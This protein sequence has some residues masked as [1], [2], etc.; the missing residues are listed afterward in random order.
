MTGPVRNLLLST[1]NEASKFGL[2]PVITK[3]R[4]HLLDLFSDSALV[5]L[6]E[7][8]PRDQLQAF[9]MGGDSENRHEWQPV[10]T[11]GASGS[12]LFRA[13]AGGRL[14]FNIFRV[15]LFHAG[16]RDLL[17]QLFGE[18]SGLCPRFRCFNETATLIIS[19]PNAFVYYH[20]DA[21]PNFLWHVRGSKRVWVYPAGDHELIDQEL[22]EDIFASYSDEEVPYKPEFDVK[23]AVF[24]LNPGDVISWPQNSPHRV[25]NVGGLNVSLSAIYETEQ[26][27]HRKLIYCANRLFRRRYRI[28]AWSIK[29][30]G[31]SPPLKT[32]AYRGIRKLG[33]LQTPP[34][35]AYITEFRINPD[36]PGG[37]ERIH[38]GPVLTEFSKK[39]FVLQ[40]DA[41][42]KA[43][44]IA[45][46]RAR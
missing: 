18:I 46:D 24:D 23:A 28:P 1:K 35:R 36:A 26:S 45:L 20:A 32:L 43:T 4:L 19:S 8:H 21:Q 39:E 9:T 37:F 15:Q 14:W 2:A 13:V 44:A 22:M 27:S 25:T 34:R 41:W 10:D 6:L 42:G 16:F 30:T 12:D 11:A 33:L 3:H 31:I 5:E 7:S 38:D 40:K 29:E 17:G